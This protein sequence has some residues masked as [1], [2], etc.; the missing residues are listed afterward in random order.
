MSRGISVLFELRQ[1]QTRPGEFIS[2]VGNLPELGS[3]DA[4]TSAVPLQTSHAYYPLWS[5]NGP[6]NIGMPGDEQEPDVISDESDIEASWDELARK[7][8]NGAQR[9]PE[10]FWFEYKYIKDRRQVQDG[11]PS[12]EWEDGI[13]N[14]SITISAEPGS[15]WIISDAFFNDSRK[16]AKV[17]RTTLLEIIEAGRILDLRFAPW[18]HSKVWRE[19]SPE[20]TGVQDPGDHLSLRN[21]SS[22]QISQKSRFTTETLLPTGLLEMLKREDGVR[23]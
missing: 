7:R 10:T 11:G 14:R 15:I 12:V 20:W 18:R 22:G 13:A 21:S 9:T 19:P 23:L 5:M 8:K 4:Y 17:K 1:A 2:V 6:I 16:P 3:W